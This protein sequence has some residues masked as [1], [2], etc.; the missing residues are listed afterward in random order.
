MS[1]W[2]RAALLVFASLVLALGTIEVPAAHAHAPANACT[3]TRQAH[4][5]DRTVVADRVA[6]APSKAS[7][8]SPE[9]APRAGKPRRA[10]PTVEWLRVDA[11]SNVSRAARPTLRS[12]A[13]PRSL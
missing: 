13:P 11:D 2:A 5:L 9:L 7:V 10:L 1:R 6:S 12:R 3:S 8:L 4:P